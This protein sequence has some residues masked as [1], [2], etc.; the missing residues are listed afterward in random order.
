MTTVAW[1]IPEVPTFRSRG[2]RD[3]QRRPRAGRA[4]PRIPAGEGAPALCQYGA[5][6]WQVPGRRAVTVVHG[7]LRRTAAP[8]LA[9]SC[10]DQRTRIRTVPAR[11]IRRV[12]VAEV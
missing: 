8:L 3:R 12:I 4:T 6:S 2:A 7:P 1:L 10:G 9:R 5:V 11:G